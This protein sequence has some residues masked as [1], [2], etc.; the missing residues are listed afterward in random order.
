MSAKKKQIIDAFIEEY[1]LTRREFYH[2]FGVLTIESGAV[3]H[4]NYHVNSYVLPIA[5]E[6]N[7]N[8]EWYKKKGF[9]K[10]QFP[11]FIDVRYP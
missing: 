3:L 4:D 1:N 9:T 11:D 7:T 2:Y 10:K 8:F 5:S 6:I